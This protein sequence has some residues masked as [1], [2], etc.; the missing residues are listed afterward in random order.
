MAAD[1]Q[2]QG[3]G[4]IVDTTS[5]GRPVVRSQRVAMNATMAATRTDYRME[6]QFHFVAC[7]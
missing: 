6:R 1:E 3:R 5:V 2:L 7:S 4:V